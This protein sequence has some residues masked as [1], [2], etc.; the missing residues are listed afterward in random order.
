M[1]NL[2]FTKDGGPESKVWG[3]YLIEMKSL[4]TVVLLRFEN[5]S[6]EAYHN[7][8]FN[9]ISWVLKGQLREKQIDGRI[10]NFAPRLK[11][12]FTSRRNFHQVRSTGRTW[13]ISFRG[14]W[15][16]R[17]N[18]YLPA[19]DRTITLTHGRKVVSGN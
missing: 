13:V 12:I 14:P 3:L 7:H 17:W 9:A 10:T 8:A 4:F 2:C 5:G 15:R 11:P 6:R 16:N 18:E 1:K 19:E